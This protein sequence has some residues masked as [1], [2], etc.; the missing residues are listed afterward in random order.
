MEKQGERLQK[1]LARAGVSSRRHAEQIILAGRVRVNGRVVTE[2]GTRV[3]PR[4]DKVEL[5]GRRIVAEPLVYYV[6]HKPRGV[7]TTLS[8]PEGRPTIADHM[9]DLPARV[10][11]VGRL[12][13]H[14]SG[15][16]LL[17]NDGAL[18]QALL[19]PRRDV[20][21]TYVCKVRGVVTDLQIEPWRQGMVLRPTESDP[22]EKPTRTLP[23]GVKVMRV[24]PPADGGGDGDRTP[25]S[26]WLE[27]TLREGRTRQI[28]R[29]A[30]ATGLFVM[31][32]ARISFAGI[33]S[34]GLR[35][36]QYRPLTREE[37]T[38]L[39]A[40]YLRLVEQGSERGDR[41]TAETTA[42]E[43]NAKGTK[44]KATKRK[45]L[46]A[47]VVADEAPAFQRGGK[48]A[49][50]RDLR[51]AAKADRGGRRR[52]TTPRGGTTGAKGAK[53]LGGAKPP[54]AKDGP[55]GRGRRRSGGKPKE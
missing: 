39:R 7:V 45:P 34:E 23:A 52:A 14:T 38:Q 30:E 3:D 54:R 29:M 49:S 8:D 10:Y 25:G 6:F 9:K 35:P 48:V 17:T 16:L 22:D 19:H 28:H 2:L 51:D 44:W 4:G 32:L 1:V 33:T 12:D 21:K 41:S 20:P 47:A 27:V 11:P 55:G 50:E 13:F 43:T 31:R 37:V 36:E 42:S 53:G 5:D 46:P 26:S 15:V 40:Q 18:A 24:T